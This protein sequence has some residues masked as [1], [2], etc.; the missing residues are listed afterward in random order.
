MIL[1]VTIASALAALLL[2]PSSAADFAEARRNATL[3]ARALDQTHDLLLAWTGRKD[4][5]S[6]LLRAGPE[7]DRWSIGTTAAHLFPS[8]VTAAWLTEPPLY[9]GLLRETLRDEIALTSRLAA[10]PDDY[11]LDRKRFVHTATNNDRIIEAS[12][13]Y[14]IG[15][16]R[17]ISH[18]GPSPWSDRMRALVDGA[19][20]RADVATDF[21]EGPLPSDRAGVNGRYLQLLPLLSAATGD[22]GYLYYARRIGDAYCMGVMP[23]NGGLPADRWDF[24]S[25]R[26]RDAE[27]TLDD[28]GVAIIEGLVS[29]YSAELEKGSTR[30]DVYRPSISNL[31]DT[32]FRHGHTLDG[33]ISRRI[34]PDGR[35]GYSIDRRRH[36]PHEPRLLAAA[37]R[38]GKLSGNPTYIAQGEKGAD[39]LS[40]EEPTVSLLELA[41]LAEQLGSDSFTAQVR[42]AFERA[43]QTATPPRVNEEDDARRLRWLA[44]VSVNGSAGMRLTPWRSD[45]RW[46]AS[47]HGD[48]LSVVLQADSRWK[49]D[50]HFAIPNAFSLPG[51]PQRYVIEPN[52]LY[53]VRF[54]GSASVATW[55]G[56]HLIKG[57][58]VRLD[59]DHELAFTV[60]RQPS[61]PSSAD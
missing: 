49:G 18:T 60:V 31:F 26:A 25:D 6:S 34:D 32:I 47:V 13:L 50:I 20:L 1:R 23:K 5:D 36:S 30:A 22:E 51:Y 40:I 7:G 58:S 24:A 3:S 12:A 53:L 57:F 55:Q 2:S 21:A 44:S 28:D 46:G 4:S 59:A 52:A 39:N 42:Q 27:L 15:L 45:V 29:L 54:P 43:I 61:P 11:D 37:A 33:R 9:D 41:I 48:T 19:F 38:F 10:L 17:A 14:A 16:S 8:L 35:G 56:Q